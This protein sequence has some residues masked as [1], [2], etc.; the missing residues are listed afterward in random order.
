MLQ[1]LKISDDP[2]KAAR[3]CD[4]DNGIHYEEDV[5]GPHVVSLVSDY[6]VMP[7]SASEFCLNFFTIFPDPDWKRS[8]GRKRTHG[9]KGMLDMYFL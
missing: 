1:E 4:D 6:N 9:A 5:S 7:V 3:Y 8:E 2:G